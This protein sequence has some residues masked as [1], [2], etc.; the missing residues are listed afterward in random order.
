MTEKPE[1][2]LP[3]EQQLSFESELAV[4]GSPEELEHIR[5]ADRVTLSVA[6]FERLT[7][8]ARSYKDKYLRALADCENI[9]KRMTKERDEFSKFAI[10]NIISEYLQPL[11]SLENALSYADKMSDEVK[12][13]AIGFQMILSQ[14]KEVLARNGVT[15]IQAL[16]LQFDPHLHEA[17]E[18][19][20]TNEHP[21]GTIVEEFTRGY[22][23]GDR[24]IRPSRVKVSREP[25]SAPEPA[26]PES[27]ESS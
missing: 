4:S 12:N 25:Q 10:S 14:F 27:T 16:G 13:W 5:I 21:A 8:E 9:R 1:D 11:D 24:T 7:E 18:T 22:M 3:L 6:E 20:E 19:V 26:A 17:V 2:Q 23:M 15:P